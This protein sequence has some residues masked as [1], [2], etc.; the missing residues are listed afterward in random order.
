MNCCKFITRPRVPA[1]SVSFTIHTA[2]P[3]SAVKMS[4]LL[5]LVLIT[6]MWL[7]QDLFMGTLGVIVAQVFTLMCPGHWYRLKN[8]INW[9]TLYNFE[10]MGYYLYMQQ[11]YR[12]K[13]KGQFL[14]VQHFFK[15]RCFLCFFHS[16]VKALIHMRFSCC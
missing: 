12:N 3:Q 9:N 13:C 5:V 8:G 11:T 6:F 1:A 16:L 2:P 15:F 14:S 4:L 7:T 10:Q